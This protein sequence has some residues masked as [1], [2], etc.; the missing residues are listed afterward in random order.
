MA[1]IEWISSLSGAS[2]AALDSATAPSFAAQ[3]NRV[4]ICYD[5]SILDGFLIHLTNVSTVSAH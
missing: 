5:W 4:K 3:R 2:A 1:V